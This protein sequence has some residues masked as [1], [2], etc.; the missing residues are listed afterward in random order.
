MRLVGC[1]IAL[2]LLAPPAP[3]DLLK[4][5]GAGSLTEP[6][7]LS[8]GLV[9]QRTGQESH[10]ISTDRIGELKPITQRVGFMTDHGEQ[11]AEW[12]GPPL[13]DVLMDSGALAGVKP[14]EQVRL[15]VR[16]TGVDGYTAVIAL[17]EISPEFAG[18]PIQI[19]DHMNGAPIP[20]HKLRLVVPGDK[21]GGRSVRNAIRIEIE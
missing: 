19:A 9:V 11:Q 3:A 7:Q 10:V 20:D 18:R 6:V 4:V 12:T 2:T 8:P 21:R 1:L 14:A 5:A 17:G 13:W 16:I 15:V